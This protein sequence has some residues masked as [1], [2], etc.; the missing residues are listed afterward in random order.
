[1]KKTLLFTLDEF[2]YAGDASFV[3]TYQNI[4]ATR[5]NVI[6]I[7]RSGDLSNPHSFFSNARVIEIPRKIG[8][9]II[10]K[11][12][13]AFQYVIT[14]H[15]VYK[16]YP[17][18]QT[19]HLS[20]TWS[21]LYALLHPKT[22]K[23]HRVITYYGALD[24]EIKSIKGNTYKGALHHVLQKLGI[25]TSHKIIVFTKYAKKQICIHFSLSRDVI[26]KIVVIPGCIKVAPPKNGHQ[27]P[28]PFTILNI[29]RAEPR[30]GLVLLL[31]ALSILK[32]RG[33]L[34]QAIIASPVSYYSWSGILDVYEKLNLFTNVHFLHS[35]SFEQKERL[36]E[37]A[38]VFVIPSLDLETFGFS[39]IES[40]SHGVPVIGTPVSAIPEILTPVDARL[41]TKKVTSQA[42]YKSLEWFISLPKKNRVELGKKS[43]QIIKKYYSPEAWASTLLSLYD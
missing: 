6:I 39:I 8:Y 20:T 33:V 5:Y 14:L 4:A 40:L 15:R 36:Y 43:I 17:S 7:G 26:N 34:F 41:L 12:I 24:L 29:G 18:I 13:G 25:M 1:M 9:S 37:Q 23:M 11:I 19:I 3:Q 42:L 10:D 28:R 30:K 31:K 16:S 38:D 27:G 32:K 35:V 21:T 22:W 2:N